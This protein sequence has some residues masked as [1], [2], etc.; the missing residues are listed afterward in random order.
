MMRT[1]S[2]HKVPFTAAA[3]GLLIFAAPSRSRPAHAAE[4]TQHRPLLLEEIFITGNTYVKDGDIIESSKLGP[5]DSLS[6]QLLERVRLEILN[7]HR[8]VSGVEFST[9]PGLLRGTVILVI[10]IEE[11]GRASLNT[12]FGYHD[13]HGWFLT[14]LGT[15]IDYPFGIDSRMNLG[16][17]LGF[18]LAGFDAEWE[19]RIPPGGG[20]G[21]GISFHI[22]NQEHLF[23]GSGSDASWDGPGWREHSQEISRVGSKLYL[24]YRHGGPS[25]FSFG[26][27]AESVEP[28]SMFSDVENDREHR[29]DDLP[30]PLKGET[31]KSLITGIF[32]Q[33]VRDTRDNLAYPLSGSFTFFSLEANN[34]IL[35]GDEVFSKSVFDFRKHIHLGK[36]RV[37]SGRLKSGVISAGAPYYERFSIGGIYS[38]RGFQELSLSPAE[39]DDGFWIASGELRV[40][41]IASKDDPP[42]LAGLLFMDAGQG[43]RRGRTFSSADIESA[44]GYGM[45][46]RLPW[47][48]TLGFDVAIPLSE[49]RTGDDF[50]FHGSLGFSF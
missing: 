47:L 17:R 2:W 46:L 44:A 27:R 26:I 30:E 25:R 9:R 37:V 22:Y 33:M 5:G 8:L 7:T 13:L 15:H 3:I 20:L 39:G 6:I 42:R 48:G 14:L 35:G 40:P 24:R 45:R 16:V 19:K 12:G 49:G 41:L 31:K 28:D 34:T 11:R 18:H 29:F 32:F 23:F 10:E 4:H 43:W 21:Y 38:I 1:R 50:R 36:H